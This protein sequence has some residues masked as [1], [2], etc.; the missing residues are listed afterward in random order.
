MVSKSHPKKNVTGIEKTKTKAGLG[1][2]YQH[3]YTGNKLTV[4]VE[5]SHIR[6]LDGCRVFLLK[7]WC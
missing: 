6:V 7:G 1:I 3:H 2:M 4:V 5:R